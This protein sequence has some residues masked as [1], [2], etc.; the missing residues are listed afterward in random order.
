MKYDYIFE[1]IERYTFHRMICDTFVYH[2]SINKLK[3]Y[4]FYF[5]QFVIRPRAV[6]IVLGIGH[7]PQATYKGKQSYRLVSPNNANK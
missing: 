7:S 4:R 5:T 1:N 2:Q 6:S 3:L